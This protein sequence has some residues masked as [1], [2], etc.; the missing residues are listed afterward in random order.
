MKTRIFTDTLKEYVSHIKFVKEN[1]ILKE[2]KTMDRI[3]VAYQR[4]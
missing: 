1:S 4:E 2:L 3:V